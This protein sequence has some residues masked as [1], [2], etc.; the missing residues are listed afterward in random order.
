ADDAVM[1]QLVAAELAVSQRPGMSLEASISDYLR[2]KELLLVLDNCEH[3]LRAVSA[4]A[5]RILRECPGV[6]ILA[7]SR[8]GLAVGGEHGWPLPSL[9]LPDPTDVSDATVANDAV[10]LFADRARAARATFVLDRANVAAVAEICRRLDGIP[11]AIE[12]AASR[13]VSMS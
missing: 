10:T 9:P 4:L 6:R 7:T 5:A 11:L 2:F 12:L 13:V 8:E 1:A 3:L